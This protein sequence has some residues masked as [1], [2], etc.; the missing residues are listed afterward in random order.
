MLRNTWRIRS[1]K[2]S[3]DRRGRMGIIVVKTPASSTT[4]RTDFCSEKGM[5][6]SV[7]SFMIS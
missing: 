4:G 5:R 6:T 3:A 1:L 7:Q 2:S